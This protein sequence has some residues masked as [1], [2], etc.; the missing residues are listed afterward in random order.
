M[1]FLE[2]RSKVTNRHISEAGV[3]FAIQF[4]LFIK[5]W[6]GEHI[7]LHMAGN[8]RLK[9][10]VNHLYARRAQGTSFSQ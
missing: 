7:L 8:Y 5:I 3:S 2:I 6:T 4:A 9:C 1:H 10:P